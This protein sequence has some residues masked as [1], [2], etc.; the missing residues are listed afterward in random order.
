MMSHTLWHIKCKTKSSP[1]A[2]VIVVLWLI[3]AENTA[4][5][6]FMKME[7]NVWEIL[8]TFAL[9]SHIGWHILGW[10]HSFGWLRTKTHPLNTFLCQNFFSAL[11]WRTA[12][13]NQILMGSSAVVQAVWL[14]GVHSHLCCIRLKSDTARSTQDHKYAYMHFKY[15]SLNS[16]AFS[17]KLHTGTRPQN[18]S[19]LQLN[20]TLVLPS[21]GVARSHIYTHSCPELY[22]RQYS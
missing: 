3:P 6:G 16:A 18:N 1:G 9:W 12:K 15:T 13:W 10:I 19:A 17:T 5:G 20:R 7:G 2:D 21:C 14:G 11:V 22:Q 4:H 8:K